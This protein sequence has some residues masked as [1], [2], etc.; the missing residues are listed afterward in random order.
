MTGHPYD[1]EYF[2][3]SKS[4]YGPGGGY[5]R[6]RYGI[7]FENLAEALVSALNVQSVLDI[8]CAKGLL[9]EGL[10]RRNVKAYGLDISEYAIDSSEEW[11]RPYLTVLDVE[12][13]QFPYDDT[14][15]DAVTAVEIF[16]HLKSVENVLKECRRVLKQGGY[17][18]LTTPRK[19]LV[20]LEELDETH[21]NIKPLSQWLRVFRVHGF[22]TVK[23][24]RALVPER[25]ITGA[26]LKSTNRALHI[27][28]G[29]VR[30]SSGV[31]TKDSIKHP[32]SGHRSS[33]ERLMWAWR[34]VMG[35]LFSGSY[36]ILLR[37][38]DPST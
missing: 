29:R 15:F 3:G 12:R 33:Q 23:C 37:K 14:F 18:F 30:K 36:R 10:R 9:V 2:E 13:E 5:T 21:I 19:G 17:L 27:L 7:H 38:C 25:E 4:R 34:E 28:K 16:E 1:H 24:P 35:V 6:E 8:G 32:V 11:I 20:E 22:I 31:L 26:V